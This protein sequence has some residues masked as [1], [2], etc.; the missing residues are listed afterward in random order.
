M[1]GESVISLDNKLNITGLPRPYPD[2]Q[3]K[4]VYCLRAKPEG[5]TLA[6]AVDPG[7]GLGNPVII[8]LLSSE[9]TDSPTN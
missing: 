1:V 8:S 7:Y 3:L 9:M 6:E 4:P 5:N 2:A